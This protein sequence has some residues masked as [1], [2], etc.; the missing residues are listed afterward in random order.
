VVLVLAPPLTVRRERRA[1]RP[2]AQ[3]LR[4]D[5]ADPVV[6]V[7][8]GDPPEVVDR[9]EPRDG[10]LAVMQSPAEGVVGMRRGHQPADDERGA[11][12]E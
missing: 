3:D 9:L 8:T 4:L 1:V 6:E 11:D 7:L 10:H 5:R 12:G 2:R